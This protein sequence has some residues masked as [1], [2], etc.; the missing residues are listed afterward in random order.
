MLS[1]SSYLMVALVV[2]SL[3][4]AGCATKG[5]VRSTVEPVSTQLGQVSQQVDQQAGELKQTN[6]RVSKNETKIDATTEVANSADSRSSDAL[7]KTGLNKAQIAGLHNVISN[8]EDYKVN[9]QAVVHFGFNKD[10]LSSEAKGE[11]DALAQQA[12]GLSRYFITVEGFT[13]QTGP[14]SYNEALSQRRADHVIE[15]LVAEHN[16]PV[17]RIH[18]IGLGERKLIDDGRTREARAESRR[19]QV[20]VFSAT[21]L[22]PPTQNPDQPSTHR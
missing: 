20:T 17:Y 15:Y 8:L 12:S 21:P 19:V 9:H 1:K 14:A 2:G 5:Y 7:N 4:G 10:E 13:D 11:L 22:P 16:I 3:G 18:K 6:T